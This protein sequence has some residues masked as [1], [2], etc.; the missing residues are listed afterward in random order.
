MH[1]LEVLNWSLVTPSSDP[2][3]CHSI[4]ARNHNL[5]TASTTNTNKH[6]GP[7]K[8]KHP[9]RQQL[10]YCQGLLRNF[11]F[12][13]SGHHQPMHRNPHW[14]PLS[15][16]TSKKRRSLPALQLLPATYITNT[17]KHTVPDKDND[18][19][20]KLRRTNIFVEC[21]VFGNTREYWVIANN[22][23]SILICS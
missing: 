15:A 22:L 1:S 10:F 6:S 4:D 11:C 13:K 19:R 2:L 5:G 8:E 7:D 20:R 18:P 14:C 23:P 21:S 17:N 16:F 12:F 3:E 9:R